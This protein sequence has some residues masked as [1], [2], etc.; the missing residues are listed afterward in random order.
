[1]NKVVSNCSQSAD[2]Q[3]N[4]N[5]VDGFNWA[6]Q[7]V[8]LDLSL[9]SHRQDVSCA[10]SGV[11]GFTR[12]NNSFAG[13]ISGLEIGFVSSSS[14]IDAGSWSGP[15]GV[16]S[17]QGLNSEGV[18]GQKSYHIAPGHLNSGEWVVDFDSAVAVNDFWHDD[19]NPNHHG[20]SETVEQGN[21][22]F[23]GVAG[24]QERNESQ[25]DDC[26]SNDQVNPSGFAFEN[27]HVLHDFEITGIM[28]LER[29]FTAFSPRKV[30]A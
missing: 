21:Q 10:A 20:D 5:P 1:M 11:R 25:G 18:F 7:F 24:L 6:T 27:V 22:S 4:G 3:N 19:E 13:Q 12:R 29:E 30:A 9:V 26:I 17:F 16:L 8:G 14:S 23:F 15:R 2:T 28:P